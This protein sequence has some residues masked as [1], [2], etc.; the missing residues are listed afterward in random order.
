MRFARALC[1]ALL[2]AFSPAAFAQEAAPQDDAAL[3]RGQ[4]L[5]GSLLAPSPATP[6]KGVFAIEPYFLYR[7]GAGTFGN[8]GA[9]R[10][11]PAGGD[12]VRSYTSMQYGLGDDLAV[13]V[14]PSFAQALS[15][16]HATGINDLPVR[17]KY[18]W[19]GRGEIGFWNPSLTTGLGVTIPLGHYQRLQSPAD[20]FGAGAWMGNFQAQMQNF[21]VTWDH[22]NRA[23]IWATLSAPLGAVAVHG[24]SSYGTAAGFSG[25]ALPGATAEFG[26]ADEFAID[27]HWVLA[28]DVAEDF[29]RATHLHGAGTTAFGS[30]GNLFVL[31]PAIEYNFAIWI[32]VIAGVEY[33]PAGHNASAA[34]TPQ[35]AVNMFF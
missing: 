20:G 23:R 4:G 32:G 7:R 13:Q 28:L 35:V 27:R 16:D 19:F 24:I 8:D 11:S 34:I 10:A 6:A 25:T 2:P 12:Q 21:F 31:A 9:R 33:A 30:G 22:P 1:V 5:T 14:L 18:R 3:I 17:L 15:G 26:I 29:T